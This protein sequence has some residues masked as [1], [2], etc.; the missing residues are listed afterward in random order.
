M[1]GLIH[2]MLIPQA[3]KNTRDGRLAHL[4][5]YT[6]GLDT[7]I[8]HDLRKRLEPLD[9]DNVVQIG[10][11]VREMRAQVVLDL[12]AHGGHGFV[13]DGRHQGYA[14][15]ATC[16]GFG[17]RFNVAE[18]LARPVFDYVDDVALADVVARADL[19]VIV[20]IVRAVIAVLGG[21]EDQLGGRRFQGFLVLDERD[22]LHVVGG[23]A[24]HHPAQEVLAVHGEDV[25]LV[26]VLKGVFVRESLHGG[27]RQA[28]GE[29]LHIVRLRLCFSSIILGRLL[30]S[31]FC[32][33]GGGARRQVLG[34]IPIRKEITKTRHL[35]AQQLELG[36]QIGPLERPRHMQLGLREIKR[37]HIRHLHTRS[38]QPIRLS[39]PRGTLANRINVLLARAQVIA[40]DN[41]AAAVCAPDPRRARQLVAGT[42][43]NSE[44]DGTAGH[45]LAVF[46][47]DSLDRVVGLV[48][49]DLADALAEEYIY[50]QGAHLVDDHGAG[51]GVELSAQHPAVALNDFD[52]GKRMEIH[53]GLGG[54]EAQ[55]AAAY[56]GAVGSLLGSAERNETLEV[57]NVAIDKN[58]LCIVAWCVSGK[59]GVR[60]R[61][62]DEDVIGDFLSVVAGDGLAVLVDGRDFLVEMPAQRVL[63]AHI[64]FVP[65]QRVEVELLD[66]AMFEKGGEADAVVGEMRLFANDCNVVLARAGI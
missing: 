65:C 15:A 24:N 54:L 37:Q 31:C 55:Q 23:I 66:L 43:A 58:A 59:E 40:H 4:A 64:V 60:A 45:A 17:A 11:A 29:Q 47:D 50:A 34:P 46:K 18:G 35:H 20:E 62:D 28:V 44:A 26:D 52:L 42:D 8:L 21:T 30:F 12:V 56:H 7:R 41:A 19:R 16:P 53:H 22:E 3:R 49:L 27:W 61:D 39:I 14:T 32:C 25:L 9:H 13:E 5:A 10:A 51:V 63:G 33:C 57:V 6:V 2:H 38:N 36:T 48:D 1:V